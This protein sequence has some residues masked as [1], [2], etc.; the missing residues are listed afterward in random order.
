MD[1]NNYL[2]EILNEN[3]KNQKIVEALDNKN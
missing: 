3:K 2:S 1:K